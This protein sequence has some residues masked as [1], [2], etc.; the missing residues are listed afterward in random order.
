MTKPKKWG[1]SHSVFA[2]T[3]VS[4]HQ[5]LICPTFLEVR[6]ISTQIN[7][8]LLKQRRFFTAAQR[9]NLG[10]TCFRTCLSHFL[11]LVMCGPVSGM[12]FYIKVLFENRRDFWR[13]RKLLV[14]WVRD[15]EAGRCK[16]E[17]FF[18]YL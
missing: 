9:A 10:D 3:S 4:L 17:N 5:W 16:R 15:L 1:G 8:G 6:D 18:W 11:G 13:I 7:R 14:L 12:I 2:K